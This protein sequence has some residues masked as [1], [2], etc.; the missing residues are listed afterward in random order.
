MERTA[1][2]LI[3]VAVLLY[4]SERSSAMPAPKQAKRDSPEH[5]DNS[6]EK[7]NQH[8][9]KQP[10][11]DSAFAGRDANVAELHAKNPWQPRVA[12]SDAESVRR[13]QL[14]LKQEGI[15]LL[16]PTHTD[17]QKDTKVSYCDQLVECI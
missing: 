16:A 5:H 8:T 11:S 7:P 2:A 10:L 6:V 3:L 1:Q 4:L 9:G 15:D 17:A 13:A 14:A 12:A